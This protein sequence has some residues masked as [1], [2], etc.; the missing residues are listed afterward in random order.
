MVPLGGTV[1]KVGMMEGEIYRTN[2]FICHLGQNYFA[3][4]SATQ[5]KSILQRR[6]LYL[7]EQIEKNE[8]EFDMINKKLTFSSMG[9]N[10]TPKTSH[11]PPDTKIEKIGNTELYHHDGFVEIHEPI[12]DSD[13]YSEEICL[14]FIF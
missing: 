9:E 1:N 7:S 11:I 6:Y 3:L 2:E 5:A 13:L 8:E 10:E 12:E 4:R 14:F